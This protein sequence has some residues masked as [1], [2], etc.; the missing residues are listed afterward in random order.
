MTNNPSKKILVFTYFLLVLIFLLFLFFNLEYFSSKNVTYLVKENKNIRIYVDEHKILYSCAFVIFSIF[1]ICL[2]GFVSPLLFLSSLI[3][4][5][6]G[7]F[8]TILS[9]TFGSTVTF[10]IGNHFKDLSKKFLKKRLDIT[11]NSFFLFIIFRFIPGIPFLVKNLSGVFFNLTTRKFFIATFLSET[12]QIILYTFIFKRIIESTELFLNDFNLSIV[13]EK[14]FLPVVMML[15]FL[16]I[17]YFLKYKTKL[18]F[19]NK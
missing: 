15:I 17:L 1:W 18:I 2:L 4:G 16:V 19:K 3:F 9:F 6:F 7:C 14:M 10:L 11:K 13:F 12:P 5:Y 8:L